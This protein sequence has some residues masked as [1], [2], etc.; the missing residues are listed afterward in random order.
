MAKAAT[1]NASHVFRRR[2][3]SASVMKRRKIGFATM[4]IA[5]ANDRM[6]ARACRLL[7]IALR[8]VF[9]EQPVRR[10]VGKSDPVL[11]CLIGCR[12]S[13]LPALGPRVQR[14]ARSGTDRQLPDDWF[15]VE[16][17]LI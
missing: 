6:M 15:G 1:V 13:L 9:Q 7:S 3:K 11:A 14:H 17:Q 8:L 4:N 16:G 5:I 2:T 12:D 10:L